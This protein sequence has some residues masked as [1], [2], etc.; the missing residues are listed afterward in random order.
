MGQ[1]IAGCAKTR[2]GYSKA[3]AFI[4]EMQS[5]GL[6]QDSVIYGALINVCASHGL[7]EEARATFEE[8]L[9]AG[10]TP[11]LF[12]YSSLLNTYACKGKYAEA[13][14][15]LGLIR[16][17]GLTPNLVPTLPICTYQMNIAIVILSPE[18]TMHSSKSETIV[19]W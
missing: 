9:E 11:N 15:V 12:H 8:M 17:A 4:L 14:H 6:S 3:K 18:F 7:E 2:E 1:V 16:A 5:H 19:S 13:E 10:V